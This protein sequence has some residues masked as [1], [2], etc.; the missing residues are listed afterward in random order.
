MNLAS[1][2][3]LRWIVLSNN[4]QNARQKPIVISVRGVKR[5]ERVL[6]LKIV[7]F[8]AIFLSPIYLDMK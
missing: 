5:S 4:L 3:W 1:S 2:S 8:L 6:F 7:N